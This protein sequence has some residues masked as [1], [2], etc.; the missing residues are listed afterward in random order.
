[1][2][3]V[4]IKLYYIVQIIHSCEIPIE[5]A[6][7]D[8]VHFGHRG[9]GIVIHKDTVI[10]NNVW[11]MHNV[12]IGAKEGHAPVIHDDCFIGTGAVLLGK[13]VIGEG[14]VIGAN[15]CVIHDVPSGAIVGGVPSKIIGYR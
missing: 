1:M 9:I 6:I 8:R 2:K 11:I 7:G 14:A 3:D 12:T 4:A 5:T 13:I 10:G 15:A